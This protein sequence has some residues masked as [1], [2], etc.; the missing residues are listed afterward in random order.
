MLEVKNLTYEYEAGK[1]ALDNVNILFKE[2]KTT[3]VL[4]GN[5]SGKSTLFLHLNGVLKPK[6]GEVY[7]NGEKIAYNKKSLTD[8]RKQV[9]IVFQNPD[10]QLFSSDVKKDISFGLTK[11]ELSPEEIEK[12]VGE[13]I[14]QT[15]IDS[16]A[17]NPVHALSFGQK[18][19]VAIAGILVMRPKVIIL[20]EP[21]AGLDP[22]GVSEILDLLEDIKSKQN[23]TVIIATHEIDLVPLYCEEVIVLDKGK[24]VFEGTPNTLFATPEIL[25]I[26]N[27]RLPRLAH[28]MGILHN[29]DNLNVDVG[30]ATIST[31]RKTIKDLVGNNNAR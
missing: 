25:R 19:R 28:L 11:L 27:L 17:N 31:A 7:L 21:T 12:R 8:L 9:G 24:V 23:I 14:I 2:G 29:K 6:S 4:G 10:D 1:K 3:A 15:G 26:H 13:V 5:G 20:D 18:K 30:A 22:V 16:I